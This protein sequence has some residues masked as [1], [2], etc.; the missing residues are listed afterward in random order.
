MSNKHKPEGIKQPL[1]TKT[2]RVRASR[3][4]QPV[5]ERRRKIVTDPETN[6]VRVVHEMVPVT[7]PRDRKVAA[8]STNAHGQKQ[9]VYG[10]K[11]AKVEK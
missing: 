8:N 10:V 4:G 6:L 7:E 9:K 5:V 3:H 2:M 1:V 11:K